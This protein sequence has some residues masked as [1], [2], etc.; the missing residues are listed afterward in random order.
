MRRALL[1][2][3]L[4]E[5]FEVLAAEAV[6][7]ARHIDAQTWTDVGAAFDVRPQTAQAR[8]RLDRSDL[9]T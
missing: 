5:A 2:V 8:F 1:A 6:D 3:R 7:N 9:R 4:A